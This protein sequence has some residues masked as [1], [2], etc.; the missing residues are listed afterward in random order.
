MYFTVFLEMQYFFIYIAI[1]LFIDLACLDSHS[2]VEKIQTK[3]LLC[4]FHDFINLLE[5]VK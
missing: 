4:F 5:M 2:E 3:F 1:Y